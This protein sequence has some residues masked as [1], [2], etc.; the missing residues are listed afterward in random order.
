MRIPQSIAL[1]ALSQ[2]AGAFKDTSPF[3]LLSTSYLKHAEHLNH[4]ISTGN[5][6][7]GTIRDD[8]TACLS[9]AYILVHQPSVHASDFALPGAAAHLRRAIV[10]DTGL[11]TARA[12][13]EVSGVVDLDAVQNL[14]EKACNARA[15]HADAAT[16]V[17]PSDSTGKR[18]IRL[19]FAEP[20]QDAKSRHRKLSENDSFLNA[21]LSTIGHDKYTVML[22]T[23]PPSFRPPPP[24]MDDEDE[25]LLHTEFKRDVNSH[26]GPAGT[27]AS[28]A[29]I[30]AKYVFFN[31]ALFMTFFAIFPF[32]FLIWVALT[33]IGSLKVSY[34]AFSKEM[35]PS[36][37]KKVQ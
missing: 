28:R 3:F 20:P 21:I 10:N 5:S 35:G 24:V 7:L 22:A 15:V 27:T 31:P 9:E 26:D 14:L 6:V 2:A 30:F 34:F 32:L 1:L 17:L 11:A 37:Q 36:G 12:V 25:S 4:G 29:P 18:I 23:T 8:L 19:S 16:G 13:P 33:A